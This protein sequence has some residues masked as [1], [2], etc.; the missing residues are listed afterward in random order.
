[1]D[2]TDYEKSGTWDVVSVPGNFFLNET[3]DG[4]VISRANYTIV[5][6]RKT[7]FYT[8]NLILPCILI[9]MLSMIVFYLPATAGE[10]VT[11][12]VSIFLALIVF[13]QVL[14]TN[15]LPPSSLSLPLF[16]KYLLFTVIVDVCCIVNTIISLSWSWRTPRTHV[17][18]PTMRKF[19]FKYLAGFLMMRRPGD[20]E[21]TSSQPQATVPPTSRNELDLS[22][23]HNINCRYAKMSTRQRRRV[24]DAG[25]QTTYDNLRQEYS[26]AIESVR[27]TA[28][29]LKNEDDFGEVRHHASLHI[30]E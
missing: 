2:L 18:S 17:L 26:K 29:H 13:L 16:A 8:V 15:L 28:A 23:L 10:K 25:S 9:S 14:V 30:S 22:D 21:N 3:E 20:L 24:L 7:L 12:S 11:M 1:M 5:L 19:F 27:F 6:R 4:K